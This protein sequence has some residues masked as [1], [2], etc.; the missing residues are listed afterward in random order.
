MKS[1]PI[2]N[3]RLPISDLRYQQNWQLA[4]NRGDVYGID[5]LD[6]FKIPARRATRVDPLVALRYE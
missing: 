4:I 2:A 5:T 3:F 1:L 6:V